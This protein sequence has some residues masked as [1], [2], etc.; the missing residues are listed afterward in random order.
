MNNTHQNISSPSPAEGVPAPE[1]NPRGVAPEAR[2]EAPVLAVIVPCYNEREVL[3]ITNSTLLSVLHE[4]K[5]AGIIHPGSYIL[6]VDDGSRDNTWEII[7]GY[8]DVSDEVGGICL[9][10]NAGQQNAMLAGMEYAST[11]CDAAVTID[12]DLQDDVRA[13]PRMV[14]EYMKGYDVVYGVRS[15][16]DSDT[17]LKRTTSIQFYRTMRKLGVNTVYNHSEFRLLSRRVLQAIPS[18]GERNLFLRGI[19]PSIGFA[20]AKVIYDRQPRAAGETKYSYAKLANLA[21]DGITSFSVRPVRMVL[22]IGVVFILIAICMLVFVLWQRFTNQSIEGWASLM[23]SL[24]FCSGSILV[25]LGIIGEYI[26]K[27]YSEVKHRPRYQIDTVLPPSSSPSG[28]SSEER[29]DLSR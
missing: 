17:W 20:Q 26:G 3:A 13:L 2:A 11:R 14:G 7:K 24:W 27:I 16:R 29:S 9:G 21:V 10:A 19:I 12:A 5:N 15:R 25:A 23:L 1:A 8:S 28:L 22:W 6:Y 18:F 4:M